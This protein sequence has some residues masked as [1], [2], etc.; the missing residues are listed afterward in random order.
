[1]KI[2]RS[3]GRG[4]PVQARP[5]SSK[6]HYCRVRLRMAFRLRGE[7]VNWSEEERRRTSGNRFAASLKAANSD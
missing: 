4:H 7:E 3:P 2:L 6:S 1:M 5:L